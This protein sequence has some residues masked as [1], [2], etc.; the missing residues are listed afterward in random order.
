MGDRSK[1]DARRDQIKRQAQSAT[2]PVPAYIVRCHGCKR[3]AA[4]CACLLEIGGVMLC[5]QCI[6]LAWKAVR[7]RRGK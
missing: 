1:I 2:A 4:E 7:L 5:D 3:A 6:E